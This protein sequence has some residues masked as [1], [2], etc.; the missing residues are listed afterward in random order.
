MNARTLFVGSCVAL[1]TSAFTFII[2]GNILPLL[3]D[4]FDLSQTQLGLIAGGAFW[5]MF[6][7]MLVGA[8]LCDGLGM[9]RILL[10]AWV[11]HMVGVFGTIFAPHGSLAFT[12]LFTSTFLAGC[13]NGLVEI[14][15]N[16]LAATLYPT[17][18]THY[19]NILHAWWP[20]GLILGGLAS[21]LVGGGIVFSKRFT[22]PGLEFG[23]QAQMAL[24]LVPGIAYL[25]MFLPQAFPSTERVASGVS[26]GDMFREVFRPMFLLWCFC[27]LLTAAT[28]LGPNQW[29]ESVMTRTAK[30]SGTLILVY[31]SGMMFVLRHFAGPLAHRMSPVGLLTGS[32]VLSCIGLYLLST[33]NDAY[34]AFGFATVFGLGVAYFWPTM[35]GVTAERFP[36]GG[37]FLLGLTGSMGNLSIAL[38]L[39]V[40]GYVYDVYS[41]R[42]VPA[43][44]ADQVV[45]QEEASW[46]LKLFGISEATKISSDNFEQLGTEGQAAVR[47]AEATGAAMAFR[48]VSIL[49]AILFFIFGAI[50][51]RDYQQGGYKA[52]IL[53]SKDEESELMSGGVQAP[54]E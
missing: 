54:V 45:V 41:V 46:A 11:C 36:K 34:T 31:T 53:I 52:E 27:M 1:I 15:I 51:I 43:E 47:K 50:A 49:P 12:V 5:G 42:N 18:K 21:M 16:P 22:I 37:A 4:E 35:L 39:P 38:V 9:K 2:R 25:L 6:V 3:G 33:A 13:G 10:I 29:L 26:T 7:S 48:V 20:G 17:E 23:W 40:M 30:V 32:A 44:Y 8:P 19:L 14:A 24:I 28:E